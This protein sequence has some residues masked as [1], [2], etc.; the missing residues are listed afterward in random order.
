ML[1]ILY[2]DTLYR[3]FCHIA[4]AVVIVQKLAYLLKYIFSLN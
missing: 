3:N 2:V 4:K 1:G